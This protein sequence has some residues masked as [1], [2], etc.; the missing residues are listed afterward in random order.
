[1][2]G[3]Y[4]AVSPGGSLVEAG[5]I[6]ERMGRC[7]RHRGPDDHHIVARDHA[8]MGA[9]RLRV[10]DP[11]PRAAQPFCDSASGVWL[12]C[13]GAIYN[14]PAL[15]A[16]YSRYAYRSRSDIE[17]ILPLY[18]DRGIRSL[19]DLDGMFALAI[20]DDRSGRLVLARDRAG[21]KPLFY[22]R[23]GS[24]VWFASEVQALLTHPGVGRDEDAVAARD[25]LT[26]G[27]VPEPRTMFAGIRK[28]EAGTVVTLGGAGEDVHTFW[29]PEAV[30]VREL[31]AD[32]A[33]QRL[34]TLLE[35]AVARQLQAD[36]PLGVFTSGGVD[37]GLLAAVAA[38]AYHPNTL[39]TFTV[40]FTAPSYDERSHAALVA[41]H[42][43][44]RHHAVTADES[45]LFE[46]FETVAA[47][48]SSPARRGHTWESC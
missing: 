16:R 40:G 14:A 45:D 1:M 17:P 37:S 39:H 5:D 26:L 12:A 23:V 32:E 8:A 27:Y 41:A 2:C 15:R 24:E 11:R 29:H 36:V 44:T 3:I 30:P 20:W 35:N 33:G 31:P 22:A 34:E 38:R 21:E 43:G 7:V 48:I 13:N 28:V 46:A 10:T 25:F 4:G 47:R 18:L 6:L 42:L 9:E 19:A